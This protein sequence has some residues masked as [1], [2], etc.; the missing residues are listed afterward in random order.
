MAPKLVARQTSNRDTGRV[1]KL[2][3][4]ILKIIRLFVGALLIASVFLICAN[5]AGRYVFFSPI[6][7]AEEVLGYVLVWTVYLGAILVTWDGGHLR[8]DLLSRTLSGPV[9]LITHGVSVVVFLTIGGIIVYQ[10]YDAIAQ[11][12]HRS[13][14]A[15]IPMQWMHSVIPASFVLIVIFILFRL[16]GYVGDTLGASDND[17]A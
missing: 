9:R 11:F 4:A 8:M 16:R 5:A 14:V 6:I 10:S 15:E 7:W 13:Q 12:N 2:A 1:E 3:Q 17:D